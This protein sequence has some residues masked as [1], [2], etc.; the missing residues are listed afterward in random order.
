MRAR[1]SDRASRESMD[2]EANVFAAYLLMPDHLFQPFIRRGLSLD[3]D[4]SLEL[5]ARKFRVPVGAVAY[6]IMLDRRN[7]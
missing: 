1:P 6:R 4:R 7:K 5:A 2:E 3:D